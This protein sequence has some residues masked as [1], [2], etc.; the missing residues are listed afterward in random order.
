MEK[1]ETGRL[2]PDLSLFLKK[3]SDEVKARG[4]LLIL[5]YL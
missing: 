3:V 5:L 1:N 4:L 2:V